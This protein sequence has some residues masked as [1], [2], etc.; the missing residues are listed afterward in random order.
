MIENGGYDN[1]WRQIR[2]KYEDDIT[3]VK[4]YERL[5]KSQKQNIMA[6]INL[7]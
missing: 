6:R 2:I 7:Q 1:N 5:I 4:E 3:I